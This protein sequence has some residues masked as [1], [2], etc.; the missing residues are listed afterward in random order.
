VNAS[1]ERKLL[2]AALASGSLTRLAV[3]LMF[4]AVF[5][6][7]ATQDTDRG[8]PLFRALELFVFSVI[9]WMVLV[10]TVVLV[11]ALSVKCASCG[12]RATYIGPRNP[13]HTYPFTYGERVTSFF[14]PTRRYLQFI[15]CN[16]CGKLHHHQDETHRPNS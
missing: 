11:V 14:W 10:G 13:K 12:R 8:T 9:G 1:S 16:N 6:L 15:Q 7:A 2:T 3:V 5:Y 4:A